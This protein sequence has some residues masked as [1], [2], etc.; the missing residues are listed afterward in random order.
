MDE[1]ETEAGKTSAAVRGSGAPTE[2]GLSRA[3]RVAQ[4]A[5]WVLLLLYVVLLLVHGR[6]FEPLVDGVL[7]VGTQLLPAAVCWLTAAATAGRPRG[8]IVWTAIGA[9]GFALGNLVLVS[10]LAAGSRLPVPS[11]ADVGYLAFY[12]AV[13]VALL[14]SAR[15][16]GSGRS[17]V[18][19]DG[20]LAALASAALVALLLAPTFAESDGTLSL[21]NVI[22]LAY[23]VLDLVL[24]AA[25]AAIATLSSAQVNVALAPLFAGLCVFLLGD[26]VYDL[27]IARDDYMVGTLL[28]ATWGLG[29]ALMTIGLGRRASRPD[30][31]R[32][33]ESL[34]VVVPAASTV[35]AVAVV[36]LAV[37]SRSASAGPAA[38]LA[39]AA[40]LAA[41]A[42]IQI[43]FVQQRRALVFRREAHSDELTGLPNLRDF[44]EHRPRR[45]AG[46]PVAV[47]LIH[48]DDVREVRTALGRHLGDVLI[49][50]I[51]KRLVGTA[52]AGTRLAR[53]GGSEFALLLPGASRTEAEET[54]G[55]LQ[56]ALQ[57]PVTLD[58]WQVAA[59]ATIGIAT[60][61]GGGTDPDLLLGRAERASRRARQARAPIGIADMQDDAAAA[62]RLQTIQ[63][64]RAALRADQL[65]LY[66]QPEIGLPRGELLGLEALLRWTHPARGLLQPDAFL[67]VAEAAGLMPEITDWVLGAALDQAAEWSRDD[68]PVGVAV[69]LSADA[70]IDESLPQRISSA[71]R[72]RHLAPERL[73]V[74]ITEDLLIRDRVRAA[75]VLTRL[76]GL[77]VRVA[78]DDF[79]TGYSS[80]AYLRELPVD[81]IKLDRSFILPMVRDDRAAAVVATAIALAHRLELRVVAE[82]VEDQATLDALVRLG[83]DAAQG[84][85]LHRPAPAAELVELLDRTA[86]PP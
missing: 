8:S 6:G 74:E 57:E 38:V 15:S 5:M 27:R 56:A 53:V 29:L 36:V 64:L 75:R 31:S 10:A 49:V 24:I 52:P 34:A 37:A 72:G 85:H 7:D 79:G 67:D 18:R 48:V 66:F 59:M 3:L 61:A 69:N 58:R 17:G 40:L 9:T 11:L 41:A 70:L 33:A 19:L 82:G 60:S 28:D 39:V 43:S 46:D 86:P 80:L 14:L 25:V 4:G 68:R 16:S 51:A 12:P 2:A 26:I 81:T 13:F 55:A 30:R 84:Y 76:R 22:S 62:D 35:V 65:E 78:L 32:V 1:R 50:E 45:A 44:T 20:A 54:A 71:L 42:R 23:P 21:G 47:L 73:E 63:D 77:G 83:C